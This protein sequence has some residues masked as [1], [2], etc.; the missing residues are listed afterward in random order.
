MNVIKI[1]RTIKDCGFFAFDG[2]YGYEWCQHPGTKTDS[3]NYVK[4]AAIP[5]DCPWRTDPNVTATIE[6]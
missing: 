3:C 4:G 6:E 5:P 2:E 1:L